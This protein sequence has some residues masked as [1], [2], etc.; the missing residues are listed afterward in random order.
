MVVVGTLAFAPV[1]RT[2]ALELVVVVVVVVG[3]V[4]FRTLLVVVG[5]VGMCLRDLGGVGT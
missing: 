3:P 4:V 2:S 1:V 5:L